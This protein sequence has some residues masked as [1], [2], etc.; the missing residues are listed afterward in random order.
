MDNV[1]FRIKQLCS[2][3]GSNTKLIIVK[4]SILN[5]LYPMDS[6]VVDSSATDDS[7]AAL[8]SHITNLIA[9]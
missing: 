6:L 5:P 9:D 3:Y 2:S 1:R 7:G 4:V 8:E